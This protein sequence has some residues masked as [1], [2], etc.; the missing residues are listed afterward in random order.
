MQEKVRL[1]YLIN[2]F[3]MGGAEKSM[4]RIL[5]GLDK[6]KYDTM[7]VSLQER[8]EKLLPELEKTGVNIV[9]LSATSKYDIR[10]AYKLYKLI[11]EFVPDVLLCSLF[12]STILGRL[13]GTLA[14]TPIIINWEHNENFGSTLRR[15]LNRATIS[16]PDKIFCDSEKVRKQVIKKLCPNK[17]SVQTIPIGGIDLAQYSCLERKQSP[18]VAVGTVGMLTKQKGFTYLIEAA[19]LVFEKNPNTRFSIVGDGPEF[20][21]LKNLIKKLQL[22][23]TVDLLGLRRDIPDLLSKWDIYVQPS[24]WEGLCIT[25]VEAMACGLPVLAS[26][27]GGIPESVF[28]G[29]NGFLVP[30]KDPFALATRILYLIENP[31][32]R[33]AMGA[34]SRKIAEEKYSLHKMCENIE[35][36][37]DD[38]IKTKIGVLWNREE[39]VWQ[40]QYSWKFKPIDNVKTI[41]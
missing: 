22:E 40:S 2:S 39:K 12:H 27:V 38:L 36:S 35:E 14:K 25:V 11:K 29:R 9:K 21:N 17:N 7:A 18:A 19:K 5:S 1:L 30:P 28:E 15:W 10:V 24:M 13:T 23:E 33:I 16:L 34:Q 6:N 41:V 20:E 26:N 32:L 4:V 37:I 3:V 31:D 8:S